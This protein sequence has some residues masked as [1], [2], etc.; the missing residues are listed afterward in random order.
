[1]S[2]A[3]QQF[4]DEQPKDCSWQ[5]W[6]GYGMIYDGGLCVNR[7]PEEHAMSLRHPLI[8][9]EYFEEDYKQQKRS[10]YEDTR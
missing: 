10:L 2:N 3:H 8:R 6:M 9:L 7:S 4:K 5:I 1:M